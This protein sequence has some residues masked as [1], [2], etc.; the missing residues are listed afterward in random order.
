MAR[1]VNEYTAGL[2]QQRPDRF[3]N[4]LTVPLPDVDGALEEVAY[5]LDNLLA[6]G[7]ILLANYHGQYLA[8]PSLGALWPELDQRQAVV[9]VHP[10][11]PP[12]RPV[13]GVASPILDVLLDT[14]RAAVQL[15]LNGTLDRY[16]GVRIILAHGGGFVPYAAMRFAQLAGVFRPDLPEPDRLMASFKRFYFDTALA[17]GPALPTLESFADRGR[18]LFGTDF[19]YA[20]ASI[21][22]PFTVSVDTD[23][24]LS[25]EQRL[26]IAN[27]N[28]AELFQ[29]L[30]ERSHK[31][32]FQQPGTVTT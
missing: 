24:G 8:D 2:V 22:T 32:S 18:M 4:L 23:P 3:G 14:T 16:P 29:R 5:G 26:A 10:A 20:P 12:L 11:E 27:G 13:P 30:K 21:V 7:V 19:P 6:D 1:R 15:V 28:A 17:S 25:A 31:T 9:F